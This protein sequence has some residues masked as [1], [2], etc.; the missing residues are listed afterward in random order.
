[1]LSRDR[2]MPFDTWNLPETQGNVCGNP[3]SMFAPSQTP[4]QGTLHSTN[5]SATGAIPVQVST[6]RPVA[7][8]EERIGSTTPMPMTARRPVNHEFFLTSGSST[9]F[10]GSTAK[11]ADIGAS[12]R[13]VPHT[14]I[15][16]VLG[17]SLWIKGVEMVDSLD[18][19]KTSRSIEGEDFPNFEVL[20]VRL[21]SAVQDH[22]L[23]L[24]QEEGQSG[25]TEESPKR[26]LLYH[27]HDLRLLSSHWCS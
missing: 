4:Y 8:G 24:F 2:S 11:T 27:L 18:E 20:N 19:L 21:A 13:E 22:P 7:R 10:Y 12:V 25:G 3:R 5:P 26:G 14:F 1:M 23:F 6:G 15:I 17:F 16:F 9:E